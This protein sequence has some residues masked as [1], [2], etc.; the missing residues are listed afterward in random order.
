LSITCTYPQQGNR[1]ETIPTCCYSTDSSTT[2]PLASASCFEN[3]ANV[4]AP[5]Y[6]RSADPGTTNSAQCRASSAITCAW[7][8]GNMTCPALYIES[9]TDGA[10]IYRSG[11]CVTLDAGPACGVATNPGCAPP[12]MS[13]LPVP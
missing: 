13:E 7:P 2:A 12:D 9:R 3:T 6:G 8:K 4:C 11:C 5:D 1:V 10:H